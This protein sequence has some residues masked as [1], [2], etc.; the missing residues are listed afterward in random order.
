M[1]LTSLFLSLSRSRLV[2]SSQRLPQKQTQRFVLVSECQIVPDLHLQFLPSVR[3]LGA[4]TGSIFLQMNVYN[5]SHIFN[6]ATRYYAVDGLRAT[7]LT[8]YNIS[9]DY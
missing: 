7:R 6:T 8:L 3:R 4:E 2:F 1:S 9:H 5:T